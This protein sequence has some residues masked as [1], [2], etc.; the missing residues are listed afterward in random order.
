MVKL[1]RLMPHR[2]FMKARYFPRACILFYLI[3][4][5][6]TLLNPSPL[7]RH[8]PGLPGKAS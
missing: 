2:A 3:L 7:R 5:C 8:V 1:V 4:S 6:K